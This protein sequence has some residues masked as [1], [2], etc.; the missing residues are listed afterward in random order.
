M[1][2]VESCQAKLAKAKPVRIETSQPATALAFGEQ[3][4]LVADA[5][6]VTMFEL[7]SHKKVHLFSATQPVQF[8]Y[9]A[10]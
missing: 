5:E 1:Y 3:Q 2:A 6:A 10:I 7:A 8:L 9:G 4:L